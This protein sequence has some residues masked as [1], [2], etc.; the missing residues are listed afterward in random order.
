MPESN[1]PYLVSVVLMSMLGVA[2]VIAVLVLRPHEDNAA[3]YT[4]IGG[5]VGPTTMAL[6]AFLKTKETH[7]LVNGRMEEFKKLLSRSAAQ[8]VALSGARG[9]AQGMRDAQP[10][11]VVAPPKTDAE[12]LAWM[13]VPL[14]IVDLSTSVIV[15]ISGPALQ[16]FGYETAGELVGQAL[17]V[18]IPKALRERHK[19]H[20]ED[21]GRQPF[22]RC[23]NGSLKLTGLKRDGS[24]FGVAI[25]LKPVLRDARPCAMAVISEVV[26]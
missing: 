11:T 21:F 5:F 24:E 6:L 25:V 14:L 19:A 10:P 9:V 16:L 7:V 3:L 22:A 26:V 8:E 23:S 1:T 17:D 20:V 12:D 4:A 15:A 2:G 13:A 18:L